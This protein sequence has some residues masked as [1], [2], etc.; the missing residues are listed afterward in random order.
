MDALFGPLIGGDTSAVIE[1]A[2]RISS[3][4]EFLGGWTFGVGIVGLRSQS[5]FDPDFRSSSDPYSED[6]YAETY[7]AS[8]AELTAA[9]SPILDA[10][11]GRFCRSSL[12]ASQ[13]PAELDLFRKLD[14]RR[15]L[16]PDS[17]SQ[18][19]DGSASR[20]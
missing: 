13:T 11:V 14:H 20:Q 8:G 12:S 3:A 19:V 1:L 18:S 7:E 4:A 2:R 16:E 9:G 15:P 5:A 6:S 10:L 17:Q